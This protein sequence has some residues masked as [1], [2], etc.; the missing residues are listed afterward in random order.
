MVPACAC[1][2]SSGHVSGVRAVSLSAD[3]RRVVS[4]S[5]Q[6]FIKGT[7]ADVRLWD[8][9]TGKQLLSLGKDLSLE[10]GQASAEILA[11]SLG[12]IPS[13]TKK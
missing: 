11:K 13:R 5:Y 2:T 8:V 6:P 12:H 7:P 4:V 9:H 3:G 1:L 10:D